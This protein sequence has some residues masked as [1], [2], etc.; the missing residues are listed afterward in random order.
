MGGGEGGGDP[1][2]DVGQAGEH[3]ESEWS[4]PLLEEPAD[5]TDQW[6]QNVVQAD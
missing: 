1:A 3:Q 2:E 4:Q 5:H 6:R